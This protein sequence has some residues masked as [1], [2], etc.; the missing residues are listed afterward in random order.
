MEEKEIDFLE[1][2]RVLESHLKSKF[3]E[4][5][6]KPFPNLISYLRRNKLNPPEILFC[7]EKTGE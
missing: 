1:K 7:L 2:V 3:P 4:F 5:K 6:E